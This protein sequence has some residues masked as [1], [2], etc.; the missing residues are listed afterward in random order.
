MMLSRL[1]ARRRRLLQNA[2]GQARWSPL[3]DIDSM[4][5]RLRNDP[6]GLGVLPLSAVGSG[7]RV[8]ALG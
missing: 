5:Q 1:D 7:L 6:Q 2:S 4:R 3:P 8:V